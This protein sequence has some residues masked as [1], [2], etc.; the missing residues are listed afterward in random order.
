MRNIKTIF[1]PRKVGRPQR[2]G[3]EAIRGIKAT[4]YEFFD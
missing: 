2:Y 4:R 1:R 3:H